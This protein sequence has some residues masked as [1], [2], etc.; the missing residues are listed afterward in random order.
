[1]KRLVLLSVLISF[2]FST[3]GQVYKPV[4]VDKQARF[5]GGDMA[6]Y[7]YLQDSLRYPK[8]AIQNNVQGKVYI[9]LTIDETGNI[10]Q[11]EPLKDIGNGSLEEATRLA[12]AMP[13]WEPAQKDG[14]PVAVYYDL[15]V[16]FIRKE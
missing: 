8:E 3:R 5:P 15:P 6:L 9:R 13:R 11:I 12:K 2:A 10:S 7:S 4:D 1:M 14:K 16:M